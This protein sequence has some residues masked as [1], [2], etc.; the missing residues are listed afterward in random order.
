MFKQADGSNFED[1]GRFHTK[2]SLPVSEGKPKEMTRA[3]IQFRMKFLLEEVREFAEAAGYE[4]LW[5]STEGFYFGSLDSFPDHA[6]MFDALIDEVYVAMGTAHL[7]GYPWQEGWD[8][9]QAA[10]MAKVR[11][12]A[13]GSDSLRGSAFD[14][15]KP[16]GW[17]APD[18]AGLLRECGWKSDGIPGPR[19][20]DLLK[21]GQQ[22]NNK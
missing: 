6:K 21:Y 22:E 19:T 10:N 1:V 15:V 11:A 2:F 18:I 14:V 17:V 16:E 9:V 4:L 7:L 5:D 20:M 3:L 12:Q 13:D 8:R